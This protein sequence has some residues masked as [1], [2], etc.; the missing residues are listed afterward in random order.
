MQGSIVRYVDGGGKRFRDQASENRVDAGTTTNPSSPCR[1]M[2]LSQKTYDQWPDWEQADPD[3]QM[4]EWPV[5]AMS[6]PEFSALSPGTVRNSLR[7]I[8]RSDNSG[9]YAPTTPFK[10]I[11]LTRVTDAG[12]LYKYFRRGISNY[13]KKR[14]GKYAHLRT[15]D[16]AKD[17]TGGETF[18]VDFD[19]S[20]M[21]DT[22]IDEYVHSFRVCIEHCEQTNTPPELYLIANRIPIARTMDNN[23]I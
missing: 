1:M 12:A 18:T 21:T 8:S 14:N 13:S 22:E 19:L 16:V 5:A 11:R 3:I 9:Q 2:P 7:C 23:S 20:G 15:C 4:D 6:Q 17:F 10:V